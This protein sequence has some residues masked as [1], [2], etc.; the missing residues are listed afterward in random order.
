[1]EQERWE[2][3]I[4]RQVFLPEEEDH[5]PSTALE[6]LTLLSFVLPTLMPTVGGWAL[7]YT[8]KA[9]SQAV[10]SSALSLA[11]QN[12]D[13]VSTMLSVPLRLFFSP[14][15]PISRPAESILAK[16][17]AATAV[18]PNVSTALVLGVAGVSTLFFEYV[19]MKAMVHETRR[20]GVL[21]AEGAIQARYRKEPF[22]AH[23]NQ[24]PWSGEVDP[25][26]VVYNIL[27]G[28]NSSLF[29]VAGGNSTDPSAEIMHWSQIL[30]YWEILAR[31]VHLYGWSPVGAA[32]RLLFTKLLARKR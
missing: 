13:L 20:S 19:G 27:V 7:D 23:D 16:A 26:R 15:A 12:R 11:V 3:W 32:S 25:V 24:R 29:Y 10:M 9:A 21:Q 4:H 5:P 18:L 31:L 17:S 22:Y 8:T 2:R 30:L 1:M 14:A 28:V 6:P